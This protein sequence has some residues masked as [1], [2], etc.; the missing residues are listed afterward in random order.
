MVFFFVSGLLLLSFTSCAPA[1]INYVIPDDH[2][3]P[4]TC[5]MEPCLTLDE[6]AQQV[7]DY[8]VSGATFEFLAGNHTLR[9]AISA[10]D[11][12]NLAFIG[13]PLA[14]NG[15]STIVITQEGSFAFRSTDLTIKN[16][17]IFT[18]E[19]RVL[20]QWVFLFDNSTVR[21]EGTRFERLSG[22][23]T[24]VVLIASSSVFKIVRSTFKNFITHN[25][26]RGAVIAAQAS[27]INISRC[28][29]FGNR[30]FSNGGA[31]FLNT[32]LVRLERTYFKNNYA[33]YGGVISCT[34]CTLNIV[35]NVFFVD[36]TAEFY[37][38]V[39][40]LH[41]TSVMSS[42][43]A[44]FRNNRAQ[45]GGAVTLCVGL[46]QSSPYPEKLQFIGNTATALGAALYYGDCD[47]GRG[48][49]LL[50]GYF[51]NNTAGECG[52][53]MHITKAEVRVDDA[54]FEGNQGSALCL[55]NS[56]MSFTG[57]TRLVRNTG[58][59][60]GAMYSE[61]SSVSFNGPKN[62]LYSNFAS[63][64]GAIHSVYSEITFSVCTLFKWN[65][66]GN[67]GGALYGLG[68]DTVIVLSNRTEF[69][70]NSAKNGGA[71]YLEQ[72][73]SLTFDT[74]SRVYT[75][76][77]YAD[78]YGGVIFSRDS[79][80]LTQCTYENSGEFSYL[81]YCF[82]KL[83]KRDLTQ[84]SIKV[85]SYNDSTGKDGMFLFGSLLDRCQ[86][87]AGEGAYTPYEW[88]R[89]YIILRIVRNETEIYRV[90]EIQSDI[91]NIIATSQPYQLCLCEDDS[92]YD[93][94]LEK[95]VT[96]TSDKIISPA[97]FSS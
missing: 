16:L 12:L 62:L 78:E 52:A 86:H 46:F 24:A 60:G 19:I 10:S 57:V 28:Y 97:S 79:P 17:A 95:T 75:S 18:A 7:R 70:G 8:F 90:P 6:Y 45:Y 71:V 48:R 65:V 27:D 80:S 5:K 11:I 47:E 64:G 22:N 89:R 40:Y 61:K 72:S 4:R 92:V 20:A 38:G 50:S 39:F 93:C 13:G 69:V 74:S 23:M 83:K 30:A 54:Y 67:D 59:H 77:N 51:I 81:S 26:L 87:S 3:S 85:Y 55:Y 63:I 42:G 58:Q 32:G 68:S 14:A 73:A 56:N 43:V 29:F 9:K 25:N 84:N 94:S 21:I 35:G 36:N 88:I 34:N 1:Q 49:I 76:H 96:I 33:A 2:S 15:T 37:G 44:V 31:I 91:N 41:K 82:I 66:A 53:A